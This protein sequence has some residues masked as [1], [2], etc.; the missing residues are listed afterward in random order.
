VDEVVGD[1]DVSSRARQALRVG[2]VAYVEVQA[3][4]LE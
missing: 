3:R 1:L 4:C 2:D